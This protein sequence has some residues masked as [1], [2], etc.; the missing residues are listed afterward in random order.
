MGCLRLAFSDAGS[1]YGYGGGKTLYITSSAD[2]AQ[3]V[4]DVNR[5]ATP[6]PSLQIAPT[7]VSNVISD[8]RPA[9]GTNS[10]GGVLGITGYISLT[11]TILSP[12]PSDPNAYLATSSVQPLRRARVEV[13]DR[14]L[15]QPNEYHQ[16]S[17][18]THTDTTRYYALRS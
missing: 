17:A 3:V 6:I 5:P 16:L 1:G 7:T 10:V 11:A 15:A 13:W 8:T 12:D 14:N 4:E 18:T 2:A 9:I